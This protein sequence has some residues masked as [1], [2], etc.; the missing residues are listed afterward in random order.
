MNV[1]PLDWHLTPVDPDLDFDPKHNQEVIDDVIKAGE[2]MA[3]RKQKEAQDGARERASAISKYVKSVVD[4]KTNSGVNKFF[5]QQELARLRGTEILN[6]LTY[7]DLGEQMKQ[8]LLNIKAQP[9]S[10]YRYA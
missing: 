6:R 9:I 8:K 2:I 10:E 3:A 1:N 4:G 7:S 5:G